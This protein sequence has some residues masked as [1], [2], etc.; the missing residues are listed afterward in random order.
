MEEKD[1]GALAD[2]LE[3]EANEL[4]AQSERLGGKVQNVRQDWQQKRADPSVPG[5]IPPESDQA[6]EHQAE[7]SP[8]PEAPPAGSGPAAAETA[9]E[10]ATGPPKDQL[11][12][13]DE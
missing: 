5:A 1:P 12:D 8:G 3:G 2:N 10:G 7:G 11:D 4:E 9:P 6:D 13:D